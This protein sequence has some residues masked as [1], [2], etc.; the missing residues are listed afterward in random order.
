MAISVIGSRVSWINCLASSTRRLC[1]TA[2]GEA[3]RCC[4]NSRRSCRSPTPT[5]LARASTDASSSAPISTSASARDT[6]LEA[7]RQA[8]RSGEVSGRQR[9]QGRKPASC[10]AAA[11]GKKTTFSGRGVRAGQIGRQ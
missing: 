7:P 5:R 6:V 10:A 8:P 2:M 3:P 9:R 1:A 4:W 11:V